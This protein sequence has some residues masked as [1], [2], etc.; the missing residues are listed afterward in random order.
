M[1]FYGSGG[2]DS[3]NEIEAIQKR[4]FGLQ[5]FAQ[6]K[7]FGF[8]D[9][10]H[11]HSSSAFYQPYFGPPVAEE[12]EA[13]VKPG[14]VRAI[15][16]ENEEM[17]VCELDASRDSFSL[18]RPDHTK[19]PSFIIRGG[20]DLLADDEHPQINSARQTDPWNI[21]IDPGQVSDSFFK[22]FTEQMSTSNY[23][24]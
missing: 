22:N 5:G 2:N 7:R 20:L 6:E 18:I 9:Y 10:P 8:G 4:K 17:Q 21:I 24:S 13:E 3:S 23:I 16:F 19:L 15:D 1:E 11:D 14:Y 12:E